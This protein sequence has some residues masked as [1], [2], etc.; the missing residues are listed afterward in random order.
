MKDTT[1]QAVER[2]NKATEV[3]QYA[4]DV[5]NEVAR[6]LPNRQDVVALITAQLEAK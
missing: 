3:I 6:T 2:T 5:F 4:L 1:L